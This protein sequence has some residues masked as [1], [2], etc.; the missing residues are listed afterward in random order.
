MFSQTLN[1]RKE[2]GFTLIELVIVIVIIGILAAIA[3]PKFASLSSDAR[4]GTMKGA[5]GALQSANIAVY[6]AANA[7]NLLTSDVGPVVCGTTK[8]P[9]TEGY[10]K[11]LTGLATCATLGSE[12]VVAAAEVNYSG[13]ANC[14]VTYTV[15]PPNGAPTYGLAGLTNANC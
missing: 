7:Q 13:F 12:F 14:K 3:L 11:T 8:V 5:A 9:T 10:A 1:L 6:A 4:I 15:A 2:R